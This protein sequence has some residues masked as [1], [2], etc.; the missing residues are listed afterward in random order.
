MA[1]WLKAQPAVS[2]S[3]VEVE[4]ASIAVATMEMRRVSAFRRRA[5]IPLKEIP[6]RLA[7][8][9]QAIGMCTQPIGSRVQHLGLR[10][11][12]VKRKVAAGRV[13]M[14][15][16]PVLRNPTDLLTKNA[17][18]RTLWT[19][20]GFLAVPGGKTEAYAE[21][22]EEPGGAEWKV[23]EGKACGLYMQL[24]GQS[25]NAGPDWR[26]QFVGRREG[27]LLRRLASAGPLRH[28]YAKGAAGDDRSSFLGS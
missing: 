8:L 19:L 1:N 2:L 17:G 16:M 11:C 9:L 3:P 22:V 4:F 21:G 23:Q 6:D 24:K 13:Q 7:Y 10:D 18:P 26:S 25:S 15:R 14:R 5:R 28:G 27:L 12:I 20:R